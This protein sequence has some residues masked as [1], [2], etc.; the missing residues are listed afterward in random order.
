LEQKRAD[1]GPTLYP[2][3]NCKTG[4]LRFHREGVKGK[5]GEWNDGVMEYGRGRA[6]GFSNLWKNRGRIVQ[7]LETFLPISGKTGE[8]R[9]KGWESG[10]VSTQGL[11]GILT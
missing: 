5:S 10:T 11:H 9:S 4:N 7:T 2:E 8:K 1:R 3:T 6:A